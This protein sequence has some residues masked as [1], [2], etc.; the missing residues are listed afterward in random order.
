MLS[1]NESPSA[2]IAVTQQQLA[3]G[4]RRSAFAFRGFDV[5]NLGRTPELL[6]HAKYGPVMEKYLK[7]GSEI[8]ADSMKLPIDLVKR[9][10]AREEATLDEY[11]E[12]IVLI[13]AAELAQLEMLAT[14]FDITL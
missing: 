11:Q 1:M 8:C 2:S 5:K 14:F 7:L 13:V 4:I 6:A 9:V 12:S 10:K 3:S